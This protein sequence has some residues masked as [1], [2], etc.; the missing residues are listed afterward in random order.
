MAVSA[1]NVQTVGAARNRF[2]MQ[3]WTA[4]VAA[5][6]QLENEDHVFQYGQLVGVLDGATVPEGFDTGCVHGPAWYVRQLAARIG[7]AAAERPA[8]ALMG[9]LAAAILA[10][11]RP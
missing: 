7:L 8:A 9:N 3:V 5:P 6:D 4:S 1:P 2:R 10:S 11:C